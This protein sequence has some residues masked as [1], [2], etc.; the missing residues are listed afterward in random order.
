M[1]RLEIENLGKLDHAEIRLGGLTVFAGPN[2]TGKSF[3]S[4]FLYSIF[5]AMNANPAQA[6]LQR[7]LAPIQYSVRTLVRDK[8]PSAP[9]MLNVFTDMEKLAKSFLSY[10]S[11][12]IND[13]DLLPPNQMMEWKKLVRSMGRVVEGYI[14][15]EMKRGAEE[16]NSKLEFSVVRDMYKSLGIL[17]ED[18]KDVD[19]PWKFT[20]SE[21]EY[22]VTQS[23]IKN[24]QI[25]EVSRLKSRGDSRLYASLD[26]DLQVLMSDGDIKFQMNQSSLKGMSALSNV[27]YLESPIYW[28]LSNALQE[29]KYP[30]YPVGLH[31]ERMK[32]TAVPGY[33][34]DLAAELR[35]EYTGDVAFP[36]IFEWLI[37]HDAINGK[38][39]VS[40]SGDMS[41]EQKGRSF[42]LQTTA[43]G[44]A[45]LGILAL[46][47][48]RKIIDHG[49]VL[50]IDEPE[51]HLHPAWQVIM[52]EA[53]FRLAKAGVKV[54]VAT[55][56]LDI[57]KWLEV[58][59]K[60]HP[61]DEKIVALNQFPVLNGDDEA[62]D[63]KMA[64]IKGDLTK[65]FFDLYLDGV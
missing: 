25:P 17:K 10:S 37:G 50:F 48:E 57:L 4:K 54:V 56:S 13:L 33:F 32:L 61:E 6:R 27:V 7:L 44:V 14:V 40:R 49:T 51:A 62:F 55:H 8:H 63:E 15:E 26:D 35:F 65:P 28:K 12:E 30:L 58:W 1:Q 11:E 9:E 18:I 16:P 22:Q 36:E 34:Y 46:L 47:I 29:I 20:V 38:I 21:L 2:N 64:K 23:L 19:D 43:T 41:F 42:P 24:F 59:V 31:H 52:A 45:N 39:S 53:L 3:V 60:K 5:G